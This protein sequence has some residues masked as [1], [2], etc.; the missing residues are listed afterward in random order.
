MRI[1]YEESMSGHSVIDA[2]G[3]VIGEVVSGMEVVDSLYSG[4]GESA[5]RSGPQYG[6]EGPDQDSIDARGNAYLNPG[7]PKLD[8]V[9][10]ARV[11]QEWRP[12]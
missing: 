8:Y 5:P 10:T 3:R 7:W 1:V 6:R 11:V 12:R 9:K 2:T 4:Y